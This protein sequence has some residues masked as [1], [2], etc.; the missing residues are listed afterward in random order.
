LVDLRGVVAISKGIAPAPTIS[1]LNPEYVEQVK[2]ARDSINRL[3]GQETVE[4]REFTDLCGYAAIMEELV[5]T[6]EPYTM[7]PGLPG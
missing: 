4:V 2:G 3:H 6:T 7:R 5:S 1:P